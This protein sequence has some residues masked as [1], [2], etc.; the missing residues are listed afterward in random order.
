MPNETENNFGA[1][2]HQVVTHLIKNAVRIPEPVLST[3]LAFEKRTWDAKTP[4]EKLDLL[5]QVAEATEAPSDI[6]R[7]F[8]AYPHRMSKDVYA[9][10][11]AA[12]RA[13]KEATGF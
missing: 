4:D 13:H 10:Y 5:R 1:A 3:A 8:D 11:V 6:F 12:L 7:H 9:K 2:L